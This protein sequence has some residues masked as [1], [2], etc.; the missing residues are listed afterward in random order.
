MQQST[1]CKTA[2]LRTPGLIAGAAR[3]SLTLADTVAFAPTLAEAATEQLA[4]GA[5]PAL[6]SIA[7]EIVARNILAAFAVYEGDFA[8]ANQ[9]GLAEARLILKVVPNAPDVHGLLPDPS[10]VLLCLLHVYCFAL[11]VSIALTVVLE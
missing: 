2:Q 6:V 3:D 11:E 5:S 10:A 4:N 8:T 7:A 9:Q 1:S